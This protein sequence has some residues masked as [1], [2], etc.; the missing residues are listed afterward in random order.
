MF[1]ES[2]H[3]RFSSLVKNSKNTNLDRYWRKFLELKL[4]EEK[5]TLLSIGAGT[6]DIEIQIA[7]DFP[8]QIGYLEPN[9]GLA[10]NFKK[11]FLSLF[12]KEHLLDFW[13]NTFQSFSGQQQYDAILSVQSWY[14]VGQMQ[15]AFNKAFSLIKPNGELI[16]VIMRPECLIA[17]IVKYYQPQSDSLRTSEDIIH[18]LKTN[19]LSYTCHHFNQK[20]KNTVLKEDGNLTEHGEKW[21]SYMAGKNWLDMSQEKQQGVVELIRHNETKGYFDILDTIFVIRNC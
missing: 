13:P 2:Q 12:T 21:I 7:R 10:N 20:R 17:E 18:Y 4:F 9:K 1:T 16:I 19:N 14:Y 6:G 3:K 5:S 8:I 11:E 15:A